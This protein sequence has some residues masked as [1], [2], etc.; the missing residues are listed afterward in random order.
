MF[1]HFVSIFK[2]KTC[3]ET[4]SKKE[5]RA[6][7]IKMIKDLYVENKKPRLK[8]IKNISDTMTTFKR[9]PGRHYNLQGTGYRCGSNAGKCDQCQWT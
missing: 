8:T 3:F 4:Y 9:H 2:R 5:L 7:Y 1:Q 6:K